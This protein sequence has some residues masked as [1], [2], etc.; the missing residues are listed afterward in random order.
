MLA[1]LEE[2]QHAKSDPQ[3]KGAAPEGQKETG[4]EV[5]GEVQDGGAPVVEPERRS[6]HQQMLQQKM[7]RRLVV[8][9]NRKGETCRTYEKD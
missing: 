3:M 1:E 7:Q 2:G 4:Q 9:H 5:D 8:M 6:P